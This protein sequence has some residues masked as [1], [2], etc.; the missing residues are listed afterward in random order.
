MAPSWVIWRWR[1]S[2]WD[3]AQEIGRQGMQRLIQKSFEVRS[4]EDAEQLRLRRLDFVGAKECIVSTR[5]IPI[6][7]DLNGNDGLSA[8]PRRL[9]AKS[10]VNQSFWSGGW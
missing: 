8:Q 3:L 5:P 7:P 10:I 9:D 2:T 4:S 1:G 6:Y